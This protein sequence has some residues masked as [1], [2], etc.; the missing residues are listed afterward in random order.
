MSL[1]YFSRCLY[2]CMFSSAQK[3][4]IIIH[5]V[6]DMPTTCRL[7]LLTLPAVRRI[8]RSRVYE[9][10]GRP[11][12]CLS[13]RP[14][15]RSPLA[16]AAGLLLWARRPGDIDRLL[17]GRRSAASASSVTLSADVGSSHIGLFCNIGLYV[18]TG[19]RTLFY[20]RA[21]VTV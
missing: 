1:F 3:M 2:A 6:S 14:V 19:T 17:H 16:V 20:R 4:N 18:R 9:I 5:Y 11:S 12:V 21:Y 13:V 7:L 15:I 10:I 8:V